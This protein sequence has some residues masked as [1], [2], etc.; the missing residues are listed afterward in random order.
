MLQ[1][2]TFQILSNNRAARLGAEGSG[3]T[4]RVTDVVPP[5]ER[6]A[7]RDTSG[8]TQP[9]YEELQPV[10]TAR[11]ETQILSVADGPGVM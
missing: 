3:Y 11:H 6:N 2:R 1:T 10:D 5:P 4:L 9:G 7:F 8:N